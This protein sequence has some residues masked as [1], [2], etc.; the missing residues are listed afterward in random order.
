M[1]RLFLFMKRNIIE[2]IIQ[3][4]ERGF[5]FLIPDNPEFEDF[6]ISHGDLKGAMHKDRV[7]AEATYGK[8]ERTTARVLKIL[9]RGLSEV[10]GTYFSSKHGGFVVSDD[11]HYSI[12]VFIPF[13]KGLKAKSGDKVVCKIISYPHRKNPEGIIKEVLGRQFNRETEVK[14]ILRTYNLEDKFSSKLLSATELYGAPTQKDFVDRKDYR[15]LL[16]FTIDGE[17][18]RD[19]DDAVSIVK[20]EDGTYSLGVHIADVSHYV[21]SGDIV[22]YEALKRGTSVYFPQNVIPMLPERLCNDLCSL[23][24]NEDRLTLSCMV[25]LSENGEVIKS[26]VYKSV[27]NSKAR[28]TYNKV[29]KMLDGDQ[30]IIS[31]YQSVYQS[32]LIMNELTDLLIEKR[33]KNGYIDLEVKESAITVDNKGNISVS[34]MP[35]DKAHKIIEEFMILANVCVAKKMNDLN[36]PCIYRIHERPEDEKFRYFL[37]FL[38][39]VGVNYSFNDELT[40]KDY[41]KILGLA[42]GNPAYNVINR[43][44]LRSM[45]KAKYSEQLKGHFGLGEK[46]YC[47]FTSPIRRYPDLF[48]HRVL[49]DYIA[50]GEEYVFKKYGSIA[51]SVAKNSSEK[52]RNAMEAERA[53]DDY[54]KMLYISDFVGDEFEG[55]ISGVTNFGIFV[56]LENGI[57]G[58]VRIENIKGKRFECDST[59]YV[60]SDGSVRYKLGQKAKIKVV[61]VKLGERRAEFLLVK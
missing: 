39:G 5:A 51:Q 45:Q 36:I 32:V 57:E 12:D 27:I 56:E 42:E 38:N 6:F 1:N 48:V 29:Q 47:H 19:F 46:Y 10:V 18:S 3:G 11:K 40:T 24:E 30:E 52:E 9:E 54:Y 15:D 21:K 7:L 59:N 25:L 58:L 14:S 43:V 50:Y 26:Q 2:G 20:N 41:Q 49:K 53:V 37:T 33:K 23:K 28:L 13:G 31:Q 17:D 4:N 44:M 55:V 61:G 16:T 8:G 22:D 60:L 35:R 34:V